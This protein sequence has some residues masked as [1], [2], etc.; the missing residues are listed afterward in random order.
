MIF[1]ISSKSERFSFNLF[2]FESFLF[3]DVTELICL[4]SAIQQVDGWFFYALLIFRS[5]FSVFLFA[6]LRQPTEI[7]DFDVCRWLER[8]C[9]CEWVKL[10]RGE[11]RNRWC[12]SFQLPAREMRSN[13]MC[14]P[15]F[16]SV[17]IRVCA[18]RVISSCQAQ[19][20]EFNIDE[21]GFARFDWRFFPLRFASIWT[22]DTPR[23]TEWPNH[24]KINVFWRRRRRQRQR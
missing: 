14:F 23:M 16:L 19:P 18:R 6:K 1:F 15:R 4:G 24:C 7:D 9:V 10:M 17:S 3:V 5:N 20:S 22:V 8:L 12:E 13:K 2:W 21:I 11:K